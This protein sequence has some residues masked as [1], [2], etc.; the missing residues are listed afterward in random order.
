MKRVYK[1]D[2]GSILN[3][4]KRKQKYITK[5]KL[6]KIKIGDHIKAKDEVI[7][8]K[9]LFMKIKK[10]SLKTQILKNIST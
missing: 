8:Q 4:L 1:K 3:G 9:I 10:M 6:K 2:G 7:K 5:S